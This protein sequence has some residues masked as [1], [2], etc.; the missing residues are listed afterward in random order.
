MT[1][2]LGPHPDQMCCIICG[3]IAKLDD[4][5]EIERPD[6][7]GEEFPVCPKC[8]EWNTGGYFTYAEAGI[9]GE[10]ELQNIV[11]LNQGKEK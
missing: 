11:L 7:D 1:D 8:G 4:T 6:V 5:H 2:K 3:H 10:D 9:W